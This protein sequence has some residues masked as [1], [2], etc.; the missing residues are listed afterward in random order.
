MF[1]LTGWLVWSLFCPFHSHA[2]A[3]LMPKVLNSNLSCLAREKEVL[4]CVHC[5]AGPSA[6]WDAAGHSAGIKHSTGTKMRV[7]SW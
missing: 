7:K 5:S 2:A 6:F 3:M 1:Y 4:S